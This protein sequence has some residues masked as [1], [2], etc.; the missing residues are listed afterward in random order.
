MSDTTPEGTI[1]QT[2]VVQVET[3]PWWTAFDVKSELI[4]V[5]NDITEDTLLGVVD[6]L[7][8]KAVP[9]WDDVVN[10]GRRGP[11]VIA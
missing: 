5:V 4:A 1:V 11:S 8:V 7:E 10:V 6:V 2:V 3:P 9:D